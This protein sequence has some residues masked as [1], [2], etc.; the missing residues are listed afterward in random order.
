MSPI[1]QRKAGRP[2]ARWKEVG[3]DVRILGIKCLCL[4]SRAMKEKNG[5]IFQGRPRLLQTGRA[6]DDDDDD[7]GNTWTTNHSQTPNQM[8]GARGVPYCSSSKLKFKQKKIK[9]LCNLL[10]SLSQS[11]KSADGK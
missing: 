4:L 5:G 3:K 11:M 10:F 1:G 7:A 6:S 8:G 2:K 9:G